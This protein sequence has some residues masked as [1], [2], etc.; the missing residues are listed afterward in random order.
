[1]SNITILNMTIYS[2]IVLLLAINSLIDLIILRI[3][4]VKKNYL[5]H[6]LTFIMIIINITFWVEFTPKKVHKVENNKR[7]EETVK[8]LDYLTIEGQNEKK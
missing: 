3:Y 6:F 7:I 8:I 2:T 4:I 5:L 1:M